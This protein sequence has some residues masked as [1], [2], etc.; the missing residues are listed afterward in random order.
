MY[1]NIFTGVLMLAN[2]ILNFFNHLRF[3]KKRRILVPMIA[4]FMFTTSQRRLYRIRWYWI[5]IFLVLKIARHCNVLKFLYSFYHAF[6]DSKYKILVNPFSW[7][8]MKAKLLLKLKS[9]YKR[10]C[11]FRMRS[12]QRYLCVPPLC[13]SMLQQSLIMNTRSHTLY[14]H[15]AYV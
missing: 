1:T 15:V 12:F 4:W 8:S 13:C 9:A 11:R 2:L 6:F 10:N 7:S 3:Q 14:I 5:Y